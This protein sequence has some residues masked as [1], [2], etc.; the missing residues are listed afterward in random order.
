MLGSFILYL[1]GMR[2]TMFQLSGFYC[3]SMLLMKGLCR[4]LN[5]GFDEGFNTVMLACLRVS[6]AFSGFAQLHRVWHWLEQLVLTF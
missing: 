5:K 1:K 2:T 6:R 4:V 3:I